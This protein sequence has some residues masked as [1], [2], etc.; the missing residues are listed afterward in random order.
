MT[1]LLKIPS[2]TS[3]TNIDIA[4][5]TSIGEPSID[6]DTSQ[7]A[8][9]FGSLQLSLTSCIIRSHCNPRMSVKLLSDRVA[10]LVIYVETRHQQLPL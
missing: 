6:P 9:A 5:E 8:N 3:E 4:T 1:R 2:V 7:I 10:R